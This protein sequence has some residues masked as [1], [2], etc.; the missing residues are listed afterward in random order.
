MKDRKMHMKGFSKGF[1][2]LQDKNDDQLSAL[3]HKLLMG[4]HN[5]ID[6][7]DKK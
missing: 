6:V 4:Y 3:N 1:Y 5:L 2:V 7:V